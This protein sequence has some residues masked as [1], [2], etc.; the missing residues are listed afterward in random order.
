M[1]K[2]PEKKGLIGL[3]LD[4]KWSMFK[5]SFL[6]FFV[7]Q[8]A[9]LGVNTILLE[10]ENKIKF[11]WLGQAVHPDAWKIDEVRDFCRLCKKYNITVI[12]KVP[13]MGHM[14]WIL[15][16]P[17][18]AHLQENGNPDELCPNHPESVAFTH[19]LLDDVME[20]FPDAP[21][22]HIGGDETHSLGTCRRCLATQKSKGDIYIGHY[23]PLIRRIEKTGRRAM[24]YGDMLLS[25]PQTLD[26]LPKST[27]I[28]DWDYSSGGQPGRWIWGYKY[29]RTADELAAIPKIYDVYRDYLATPG[30]DLREFPYSLYLK[31]KGFDVILLS[32]AR[33]A[34]DNYCAPRTIYSTKCCMAAAKHAVAHKLQG[35][36][37]TS[38]AIRFNHLQTSWPAFAAAA[39]AYSNPSLTIEQAGRRFAE[40]YFGLKDI[41]VLPIFDM[42]SPFLPDLA[43]KAC[44][45]YPPDIIHKYLKAMYSG[46]N[47]ADFIFAKQHVTEN[48]ESY[49]AGLNS[50]L[51]LQDKIRR[52]KDMFDHWLLAAKTLC[53]KAKALPTIFSIVQKK[54]CSLK[55]RKELMKEVDLLCEAYKLIFGKTLKKASFDMEIMLRFYEERELLSDSKT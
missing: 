5:K 48:A 34:G 20:L 31:D 35:V 7:R 19:R 55:V 18:W 46:G 33:H 2:Q 9:A 21:A 32:S 13:L 12:P 28:C 27:M 23:I 53:H 43:A 39:W 16:W 26:H 51:K 36:I 29:V 10:F 24:I 52:N 22:I 44:T 40:E 14:R 25:H 37:I 11:P 50:L 15:Q 45:P 41:D 8:A 38:W 1:K 49:K 17:Q 54:P 42:L 47:S 4:L 6:A 30:G 3:H